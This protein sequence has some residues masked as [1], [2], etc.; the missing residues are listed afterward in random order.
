[1]N[2]NIL[3]GGNPVSSETKPNEKISVQNTE[4]IIQP[5]IK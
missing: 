2:L 4:E 3:P 5:N 1:M